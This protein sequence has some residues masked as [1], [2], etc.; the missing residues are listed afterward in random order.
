MMFIFIFSDNI[1]S[2]I[3]DDPVGLAAGFGRE[4]EV[5]VLL[6]G[7]ELL[8]PLADGPVGQAADPQPHERRAA[9]QVRVDVAED[10]LPF[11]ARVGRHDDAFGHAEQLPEDVELFHD[12]RVGL[13]LLALADLP[14]QEDERR[15]QDGQV[16]PAETCDAVLL[17][18]RQTD[19]VAEGPGDGVAV[20]LDK[21]VFAVRGSHD[22]GDLTRHRGFFLSQVNYYP[23]PLFLLVCISVI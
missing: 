17:G 8:Q 19:Q 14:G 15:G 21:T 9:L 2:G 7:A 20:S 6:P 13:V 10:Q 22:G 23:K 5:V 16:L 1:L 4:V 11:A 3:T 12:A 18:H